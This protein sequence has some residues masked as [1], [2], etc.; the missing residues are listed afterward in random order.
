MLPSSDVAKAR[1]RDEYVKR[2]E[3][4]RVG[5]RGIFF[6]EKKKQFSVVNKDK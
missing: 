5:P 2:A 1:N 6:L 3:A 4:R